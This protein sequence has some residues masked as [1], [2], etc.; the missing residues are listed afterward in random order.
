MLRPDFPNGATREF[1]NFAVSY[2]AASMLEIIGR[3]V[4]SLSP[5]PFCNL[6]TFA[7]VFK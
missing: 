1:K 6:C 7:V 4:S 2:E 5:S 3:I